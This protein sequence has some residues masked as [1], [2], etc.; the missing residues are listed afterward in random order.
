MEVLRLEQRL[1]LIQRVQS[2][3]ERQHDALTCCR[4]VQTRLPKKQ[5]ALMRHVGIWG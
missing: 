2:D 4:S 1:A 5:T 3:S